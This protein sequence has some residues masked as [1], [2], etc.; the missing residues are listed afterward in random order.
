MKR[1]SSGSSPPAGTARDQRS[2]PVARF[3]GALLIPGVPSITQGE[4]IYGRDYHAG[5]SRFC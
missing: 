1:G 2:G 4:R 3:A 5:C